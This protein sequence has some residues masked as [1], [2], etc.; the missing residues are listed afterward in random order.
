[1]AAILSPI[2][3]VSDILSAIQ[4]ILFVS[5]SLIKPDNCHTRL[6]DAIDATH[7][8]RSSERSSRRPAET[9]EKAF[10]LIGSTA[11][12]KVENLCEMRTTN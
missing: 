7:C 8:L 11:E 10:R 12:R 5:P 3:S 4:A 2:T 9:Q 1:M 6:D